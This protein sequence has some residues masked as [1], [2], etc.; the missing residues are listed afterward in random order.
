MRR[1]NNSDYLLAWLRNLPVLLSGAGDPESNRQDPSFP[2]VDD[3]WAVQSFTLGNDMAIDPNNPTANATLTFSDD[4]NSLSLWNGTSGAWDTT[5][6]Y[7]DGTNGST[8][9]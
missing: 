8:L 9:S 3:S 7:Q 4:F 6:P 2:R 5:Y 1:R